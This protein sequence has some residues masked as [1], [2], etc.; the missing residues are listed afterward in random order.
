MCV[1]VLQVYSLCHPCQIQYDFIGKLETV[2]TDSEQLLKLL[3]VDHLIHFP[4]GPQNRTTTSWESDWFERIPV[5]MRKE[6]YKLYE[7]D[8][9][10]FGY[11]K[12]DSVLHP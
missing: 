10:L 7:S 3:G 1:C 4:S 5:A 11:P 9:E 2:E 8:F 6:L 12:P